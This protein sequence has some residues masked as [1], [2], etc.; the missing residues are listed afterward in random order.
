MSTVIG[1]KKSPPIEL[2][3]PKLQVYHKETILDAHSAL[4][5]TMLAATLLI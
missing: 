3:I 1:K 4:A 5:K 2:A